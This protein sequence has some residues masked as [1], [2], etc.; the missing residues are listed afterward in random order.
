LE[1]SYICIF[2][3]KLSNWFSKQFKKS[4][5]LQAFLNQKDKEV[6]SER[7]IGGKT[8]NFLASIFK[9]LFCLLRLDKALEG[10]IFAMPYLWALPVIALA[11]F[12]PTMAVLGLV[13]ISLLSLLMWLSYKKEN[14]LKFFTLNKYVLLYIAVYIYSAVASVSMISS[15]K[16]AA[17]T[18]GL[19]LFYFTVVN[20]IDTKKKFDIAMMIFLAGGVLVSLYGIYQ[21]LFPAKFSGVWVDKEM[22]ESIGFRVYSTFANPNVLG[23]YLLLVIPFTAAYFVTEKKWITKLIALGSMG[24]MMLC[25]IL[26]FSR[27]CWL[28]ILIAIAIFLVLLDKRFILL[29]IVG[30]FMLPMIMPDTIIQRFM[31]IGNMKDS[32]TSYRVNIWLGTVSMLKDYWF[33]GVGPGIDAYNKVYPMYGYNGI[34]APH[35]H[36]LYLQIICDTGIAG[37]TVFIAIL[38]KFYRTTFSQL[39]V[40]KIKE[41]KVFIIAS[42]AAITAFAMQSFTD[43]TFYNYRVLLIFWM[44]LAFG[45]VTTKLSSFEQN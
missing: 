29:G 32:S 16:V 39:V 13:V 38:Y 25:L 36:N 34:A 19:M 1:S 11:P 30:L 45:T 18:V 17:L 35:S 22:F 42:I 33:S 44:V 21:Y 41:N 24:I 15:I 4:T 28:G 43:Y 9:K 5:I 26:T 2:F 14:K 40:E 10:S 23:E 20:A 37:I 6:I 31:S 12:M 7:S 3:S 27:G 8:A